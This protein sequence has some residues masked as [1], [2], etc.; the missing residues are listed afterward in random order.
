[1]GNHRQNP[2]LCQ[3]FAGLAGIILATFSAVAGP[4]NGPLPALGSSVLDGLPTFADVQCGTRLLGSITVETPNSQP[5]I[6]LSGNGHPITLI[7]DTGAQRTL[8]TPAAA[9]RIGAQTPRVE[10]QP[11]MRGIAGT[12]ATREVELSSFTAGSVVMPWRR[13]L[14]ATAAS[15][16]T[17]LDGLLGADTLS[18]FDID[19]DLPRHRLMFYEKQSCPSA[20]P[21]WAASS[22]EIDTGRSRADH[23]FFPVHLDGQRVF[24]IIDTG[25]QLTT[26]A[27]STARALGVTE[28][29]LARDR[30]ITARGA[31]GE[32]LNSHI[33]RF[34]RLEVGRE[35][36]RDPELV[37]ADLKLRDADIVLGVDFLSTRRL[38]LS[39]GSMRL[40]LSSR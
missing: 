14:V 36:V 9:V 23:L 10:F 34:S 3:V 13:A 8:L 19:L 32:Q 30:A 27:A 7:L 39:Y 26:L 1:L 37:V 12:M 2:K 11:Q 24:A 5:I 6:T 18:D 28:E 21:P 16:N 20:A 29:I 4:G 31:V 22:G 25:A 40:F 38:W 17:P 33:H 15:L 35:I